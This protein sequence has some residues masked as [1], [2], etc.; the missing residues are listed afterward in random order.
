M[1]LVQIGGLVIN[2]DRVVY[3][4][5]CFTSETLYGRSVQK[6]TSDGWIEVFFDDPGHVLRLERDGAEALRRYLSEECGVRLLTATD[7]GLPS[8]PAPAA[9][10]ARPNGPPRHE[11]RR[12]VESG[13]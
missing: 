3:I 7:V 6:G 9:A 10:P 13:W 2:L 8:E 12:L 5:E 11:G 4:K 1:N